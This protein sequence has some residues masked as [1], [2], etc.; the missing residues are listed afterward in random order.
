MKQI[1]F[2][3]LFVINYVFS[4][5]II[6]LTNK[7]PYNIPFLKVKYF[8]KSSSSSIEHPTVSYSTTNNLATGV[9]WNQGTCHH[10]VH[11]LMKFL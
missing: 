4:D 1:L 7:T 5:N 2:S 8:S 6:H 10:I 3:F 11:L 9:Q